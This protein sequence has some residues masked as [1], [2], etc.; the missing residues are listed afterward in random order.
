MI[1]LPD[2]V[3]LIE[4]CCFNN[5]LELTQ[6]VASENG[7]LRLIEQHPFSGSAIESLVLPKR[8]QEVKRWNAVKAV[9]SWPTT[10]QRS[11]PRSELS[12]T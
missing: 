6:F 7:L 1:M 10:A 2:A 3:T 12:G 9:M 4:D 5:C 8:L 11:P